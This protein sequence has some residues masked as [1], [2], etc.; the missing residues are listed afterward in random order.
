M[1]P[2][3][4][5]VSTLPPSAAIVEL[6]LGE[7]AFDVRYMFYSTTHWRPLVNG[8]SGG[9][10]AAYERLDQTLQDALT[11]P[12]PAWQA[13]VASQASHVIVHEAFYA[14]DR[15]PRVS[16]WLRSH[17]AQELAVFGSDR[18]FRIR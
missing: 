16:E 15:G 10:P 13:L 5:F 12:E 18:I 4:G 6:P 17:G 8:Y 9:G 14:E 3:Y 11:R 1:P 7:P 2:V